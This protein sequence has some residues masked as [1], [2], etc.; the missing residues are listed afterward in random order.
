MPFV[1]HVGCGSQA[2]I[3]GF[4]VGAVDQ[5][6]TTDSCGFTS[7]IDTHDKSFLLKIMESGY[8]LV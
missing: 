8:S 5:L 3:D 2:T 6:S 7:R 4:E 1:Y